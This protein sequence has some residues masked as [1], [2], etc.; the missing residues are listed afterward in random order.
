[1]GEF[2][3]S[4]SLEY[5][6]YRE[7]LD[8]RTQLVLNQELSREG[9]WVN[10]PF[11]VGDYGVSIQF[12]PDCF[13]QPSRYTQDFVP[14]N[15]AQAPIVYQSFEVAL[16]Y[17]GNEDTKE[18]LIFPHHD[19]RLSKMPWIHYWDCT[20]NR[21]RPIPPQHYH[22]ALGVSQFMNVGAFVPASELRIIL[23]YLSL[24]SIPGPH[25]MQIE[26]PKADPVARSHWDSARRARIL[27]YI[28]E[29]IRPEEPSMEPPEKE[30]KKKMS[31]IESMKR[32]SM[33]KGHRKVITA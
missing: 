30:A 7:E 19:E 26:L 11:K 14:P 31:R 32:N 29:E 27:E 23:K 18:M 6:P 28:I 15:D 2:I 9:C 12:G 24:I 22:K 4:P 10:Y 21:H 20:F 1:M 3:C 13:C 16:W 33:V 25:R 17:F 5:L 8:I